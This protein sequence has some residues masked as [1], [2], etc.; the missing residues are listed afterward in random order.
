VGRADAALGKVREVIADAG[1]EGALLGT[2]PLERP[3][4]HIRRLILRGDDELLRDTFEQLHDIPG[5]D[6][7]ADPLSF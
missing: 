2:L 4:Y 3:P 7:E 6:I 1:L 5:V